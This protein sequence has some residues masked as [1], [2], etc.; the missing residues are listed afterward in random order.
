[1]LI[2][3]CNSCRFWGQTA[4]RKVRES[5]TSKLSDV[6]P[7][8]SRVS[9][10][11]VCNVKTVNAA[12]SGRKRLNP[13]GTKPNSYIYKSDCCLPCF[14]LLIL[15][16]ETGTSIRPEHTL[17]DPWI[18]QNIQWATALKSLYEKLPLVPP[19]VAEYQILQPLYLHWSQKNK[20]CHKGASLCCFI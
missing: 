13:R 8:K 1:M 11:S 6:T 5:I 16:P 18:F 14:H 10:L 20:Q 4:E 17:L 3:R 9:R 19:L 7:R 15:K 2:C 12:L